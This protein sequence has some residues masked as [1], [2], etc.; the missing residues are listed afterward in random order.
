MKKKNK[1]KIIEVDYK[2]FG[3]RMLA[4][5]GANHDELVKEIGLK[6]DHNPVTLVNYFYGGSK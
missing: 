2:A 6:I 3:L 5:M 4:Q 1:V